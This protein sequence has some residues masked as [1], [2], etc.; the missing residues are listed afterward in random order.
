MPLY[1]PIWPLAPPF[2]QQNL[3]TFLCIISKILKNQFRISSYPSCILERNVSMCRCGESMG[4][5]GGFPASPLL[6]G[7]SKVPCPQQRLCTS[8]TYLWRTRH[9]A[10][11]DSLCHS[12]NDIWMCEAN[13][14]PLYILA[15]REVNSSPYFWHTVVIVELVCCVQ[16][17]QSCIARVNTCFADN[18]WWQPRRSPA[19]PKR[20]TT[21]G[22]PERFPFICQLPSE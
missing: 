15:I 8:R 10:S 4:Y 22:I 21:M 6:V 16:N 2:E 18:L 14:S 9:T 17:V 13:M 11:S 5:A 7:M 1:H 12:E 3:A 19:E 20:L